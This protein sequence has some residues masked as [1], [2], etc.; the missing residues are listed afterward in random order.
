MA[1]VHNTKSAQVRSK[2]SHPVIDSDGH[3]LDYRPAFMDHLKAVGGPKM[4]EGFAAQLAGTQM[5][6]VWYRLNQQER[7]DQRPL[8][9]PWW[10][11]P[12]KDTLD[13]ATAPIP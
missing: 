11:V 12:T 2:L 7:R 4:L 6:P 1:F 13:L 5:D 9:T 8:R 3:S 10:N